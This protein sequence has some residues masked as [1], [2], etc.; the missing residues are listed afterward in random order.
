M[1]MNNPSAVLS[2]VTITGLNAGDSVTSIDF[3]PATGELYGTSKNQLYVIDEDTGAA[4]PVGG[5]FDST[6]YGNIDSMGFGP[7]TDDIGVLTD[8]SK[9]ALIDP[10]TGQVNTSSVRNTE[11]L[12]ASSSDNNVA[13]ALTSTAYIIDPKTDFLFGRKLPDGMSS[14]RVGSGLGINI[15]LASGFD[16]A[17]NGLAVACVLVANTR[18]LYLVDLRRGT[19]SQRLGTITEPIISL[20]IPTAPVA[21]ATTQADNER[22]KRRLNGFC[23]RCD[24]F[25]C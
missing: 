18:L 4:R 3:R 19:L 21:Y 25:H 16:I 22:Q 6:G 2:T 24:R 13:G 1:N 20:A 12:G 11:V 7:N 9:N 23:D 14:T 15:D 8:A 10:E 17:P 5:L